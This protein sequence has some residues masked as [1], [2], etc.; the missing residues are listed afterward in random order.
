MTQSAQVFGQNVFSGLLFSCNDSTVLTKVECAGEFM[1][2]T[3][4]G[5]AYLAP[6]VWQNPQVWSFDS[7][8][9]ALL[10]LF[11][12]VSL[13]GWIDVMESVMTIKGKDLNSESNASQWNALFFV[14]FNAVGA[15]F[16]LTLFVSLIIQNFAERS[17]DSLLTTE[18]RQWL[19]L[20]RYISRQRPA[21]RPAR[22]PSHREPLLS[23]T[24]TTT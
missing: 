3:V 1:V 17:N 10:I 24:K 9:S 8:K 11:E 7:F 15:V 22:R 2:E 21:K 12:I 6:R 18:Q 14:M 19:D 4:E 16:I 5:W 20:R 13:E 23:S